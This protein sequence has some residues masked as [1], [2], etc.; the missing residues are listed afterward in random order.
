MMDA[1][2]AIEMPDALAPADLFR[3]LTDETRL[4]ALV[5]MVVEGE[6]CVCELTHALG[7]SQ[8]KMSRH[9]AVLREAGLV[10]GRRERIWIY[11]RLAEAMPAWAREAL[12]AVVRGNVG[13][14]PFREDRQRLSR[15]PDR[16]GGCC[17]N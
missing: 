17:R 5:L 16:P 8:P 10:A 12:E 4:R 3:A 9:L 2:E 15:M 7:V 13:A 6:L 14:H 11:Y 1:A